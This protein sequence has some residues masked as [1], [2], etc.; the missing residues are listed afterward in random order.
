MIIL[1][2]LNAVNAFFNTIS[3]QSNISQCTCHLSKFNKRK[4]YMWS[5]ENL[6]HC[7]PEKKDHTLWGGQ[8]CQLITF[9]DHSF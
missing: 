1:Q 2:D 6:N 4:T 9:L 8:F 3:K 5:K 7:E